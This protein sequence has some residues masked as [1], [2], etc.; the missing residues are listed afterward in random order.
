ML[1]AALDPDHQEASQ[2]V[3]KY[4]LAQGVDGIIFP[5]V[6]G[7][8]TNLVVFK[9][10]DPAP[11]VDILNRDEVLKALREFARRIRSG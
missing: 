7:G 11:F 4:L 8:G 5:S 1:K 6:L 9:D 10:V 2:D 3:G